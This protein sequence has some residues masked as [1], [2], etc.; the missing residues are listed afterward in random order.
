MEGLVSMAADYDWNFFI[1]LSGTIDNLRKQTRDRF[2]KDLRNSEG[3]LW[4]ILDFTSEDKQFQA[5]ELKLNPL[6][7]SKISHKDTL[8]FA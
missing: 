1:I 8:L 6:T 3:I 7:G 5:E 4:R 2:K